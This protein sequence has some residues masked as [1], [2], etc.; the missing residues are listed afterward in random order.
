[1]AVLLEK[2]EEKLKTKAS[3]VNLL[4]PMLVVFVKNGSAIY[5]SSTVLFVAR[6]DGQPLD[7][8]NIIVMW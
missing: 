1:M 2:P 7:G 4:L 5:I 6:S 8:S 3:V